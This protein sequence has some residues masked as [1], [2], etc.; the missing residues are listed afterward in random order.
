MA[1]ATT[2]TIIG[3]ISGSVGSVTFRQAKN[4]LV[5]ARKQ[6]SI[7]Q[8]SEG[9]R[10]QQTAWHRAKTRWSIMNKQTKQAWINAAQTRQIKDRLGTTRNVSGYQLFLSQ[11]AWGGGAQIGGLVTP[12]VF[13]TPA[14]D[15]ITG[16]NL[17]EDI[18][19]AYALIENPGVKT[20]FKIRAWRPYSK[21]QREYP[22]RLQLIAEYEGS[23]AGT[24]TIFPSLFQKK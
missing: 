21:K 18:I 9:Q 10:D 20:H 6:A 23:Y 22:S 16:S 3:S 8:L 7:R 17:G 5:V 12:P 19:L 4:G 2:S 24:F 14:W 1:K 11:N 15:Y 13:E